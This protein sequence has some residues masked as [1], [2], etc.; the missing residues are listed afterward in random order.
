M[1][2]QPQLVHNVTSCHESEETWFSALVLTKRPFKNRGANLNLAVPVWLA[3]L[4]DRPQLIEFFAFDLYEFDFLS[5]AFTPDCC[6]VVVS[7]APDLL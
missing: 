3:K 6:D 2:K 1:C 4:C 5:W 7:L